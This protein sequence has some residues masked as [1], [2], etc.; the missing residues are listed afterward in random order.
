MQEESGRAAAAT[1]PVDNL[2]FLREVEEHQVM[3]QQNMQRAELLARRM[4]EDA[5]Q[6]RREARENAKNCLLQSAAAQVAAANAQI[7]ALKR[8]VATRLDAKLRASSV[9]VGVELDWECG[10]EHGDAAA[11]ENGGSVDAG[12]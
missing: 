3:L 7:D 5:A 10:L 2:E 9:V 8:E 6:R 12:V 4:H 1:L 11:A